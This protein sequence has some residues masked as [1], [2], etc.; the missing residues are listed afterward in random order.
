MFCSKCGKE[1]RDG[2]KFCTYC[3]AAVSGRGSVTVSDQSRMSAARKKKKTAMIAVIIILVFLIFGVA[4]A[5]I[6]LLIGNEAGVGT[7]GKKE[8][9]TSPAVMGTPSSSADMESD[10]PA[11]STLAPSATEISEPTATIEPTPEE[12]Q[13]EPTKPELETPVEHKPFY[14]IWC[15]ASE[16]RAEAQIDADELSQKGLD[17]QIVV[18]TDWSNLNKTKW[19]V[20][21]AGVYSSNE[22]AQRALTHIQE[23]Y[24]KAYVKYTGK[25]QG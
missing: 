24:P 3:G 21:T 20:V 10:A 16:T 18:T 23:I 19:Y 14:G 13:T 4:A 8:S 1:I 12:N 22:E 6:W 9:A 15:T 17:P 11:E 25:W 7:E 2:M 5:A